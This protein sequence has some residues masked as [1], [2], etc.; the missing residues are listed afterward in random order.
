MKIKYIHKMGNEKKDFTTFTEIPDDIREIILTNDNF[1][2]ERTF[3]KKG[4]GDP[5]EIEELIIDGKTFTY[6]NKGIHYMFSG[7]KTLQ[8]IFQVFTYFFMEIRK[9]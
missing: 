4:L 6:Y 9:N 2:R 7:D 5:D 8:P 1:K 3:G